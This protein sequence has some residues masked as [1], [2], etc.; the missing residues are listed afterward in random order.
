M[1]CSPWITALRSLPSSAVI[2]SVWLGPLSRGEHWK[3]HLHYRK[4]P[5]QKCPL[6]PFFALL[7][8]PCDYYLSTVTTQLSEFPYAERNLQ[9]IDSEMAFPSR[10]WVKTECTQNTKHILC[11]STKNRTNKKWKRNVHKPY[12]YQPTLISMK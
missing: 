12:T 8:W 2:C 6:H 11:T 5:P 7:C 10:Y 1:V 3:C 4:C 9:N